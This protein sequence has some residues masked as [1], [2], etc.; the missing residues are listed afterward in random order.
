[1]FGRRTMF[2]VSMIGYTLSLLVIGFA[3]SALYFDILS[4]VMGIFCAS[5]VPPAVG[6]LGSVYEKPSPRKNKAFACF[7]A[8]KS[9]P[10]QQFFK[11]KLIL[12]YLS[13]R[14]SPRLCRRHARFRD[15][16]P[17]LDLAYIFLG[18]SS[19]IR[20]LL[21]YQYIHCS[22]GAFT[23]QSCIDIG[24]L[25]ETRPVWHAACYRWYSTFL[26]LIVV[27]SSIHLSFIWLI[28]VRC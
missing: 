7:S 13:Y 2:T 28:I 19:H 18:F 20:P 8:G 1:M 5:S 12:T 22:Q 17:S 9:F 14:Q 15:C 27:S 21:D 24:K 16:L 4:G 11:R 3:N 10:F 23:S 6:I 26:K 25:K